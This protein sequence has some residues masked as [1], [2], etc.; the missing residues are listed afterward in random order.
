MFRM[1]ISAATCGR[2]SR[3]AKCP[4]IDKARFALIDSGANVSL[5]TPELLRVLQVAYEAYD[6]PQSISTVAGSRGD[7]LADGRVNVGGYLGVME[8]VVDA[9]HNLI[10]TEVL[11][12]RGVNVS[13]IAVD[14]T[15]VITHPDGL[16]VVISQY[17]PTRMWYLDVV[18][19][20]ELHCLAEVSMR[21]VNRAVREGV[22][23]DT[24]AYDKCQSIN[25]LIEK[26]LRLHRGMGHAT[27]MNLATGIRNGS[28][29]GT[30]LTYDDIRKVMT[31]LQCPACI[32]AKTA[33]KPEP[34]GSGIRSL[35]PF[36]SIAIDYLGK[37]D[38]AIGGWTGMI[39]GYDCHT[40]FGM[41]Y[42]V[43]SKD[44]D[45]YIEA[46][47]HFIRF[48]NRFRYEVRVVR[49]DAGSTEMSDTLGAYLS[50]RG[51]QVSP[52]APEFQRQNPAE[53]KIRTMKEMVAA[54][55][56]DQL[57]LPSQYWA[58]CAL[59]AIAC[60][61]T[62]SN[63]MC[64]DTSPNYQ[65]MG[66][67]TDTSKV[68]VHYFGELVVTKIVG[69]KVAM[70]MPRNELGVIVGKGNYYTKE[71]LIHR[72]G[73]SPYRPVCREDVRSV[74]LWELPVVNHQFQMMWAPRVTDRGITE[75]RCTR[76][77][78]SM[79]E[80]IRYPLKG[81]TDPPT[82]E[83]KVQGEVLITDFRSSICEMVAPL[84][85]ISADR[86]E[87]MLTPLPAVRENTGARGLRDVP[88]EEEPADTSPTRQDYF[89][90]DV[91]DRN[92]DEE[93]GEP[94]E[95]EGSGLTV[96]EVY[97][98]S[99][100]PSRAREPTGSGGGASRD[101]EPLS[102]TREPTGSGGGALRE[103]EPLSYTREPAG[104]G[105]AGEQGGRSE[106]DPLPRM[107]L[108]ETRRPDGGVNPW[109]SG[110][111]MTEDEKTRLRALQERRTLL[112]AAT[113]VE[114]IPDETD[115]IRADPGGV[116]CEPRDGHW[117]GD[118]H[119]SDGHWPGDALQ[120]HDC[121]SCTDCESLSSNRELLDIGKYRTSRL[122]VVEDTCS[123]IHCMLM[124]RVGES[125]AC[126]PVGEG[127]Q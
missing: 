29:V 11:M 10:S 12:S 23:S 21:Q 38:M 73:T 103:R 22:I 101:R 67:V 35:L 25:T 105:Q 114:H 7:L 20:M 112:A 61:N 119:Q 66:L 28:I 24:R 84:A 26:V 39:V 89:H 83:Q 59:H 46:M 87:K 126:R 97:R 15:C 18:Q 70:G 68:A 113:W 5:A 93:R 122:S 52:A 81:D 3:T 43:K 48:A 58:Q 16:R 115:S 33:A 17:A 123:N 106:T 95:P 125:S 56:E 55:M 14:K 2:L 4:E 82:A 62:V 49:T 63:V 6:T 108:R 78:L 69:Q 47:N 98:P 100:D 31:H 109:A 71:W 104:S 99:I 79:S 19:F 74:D 72:F 107:S 27:F 96:P 32:L 1:S 9:S 127:L 86:V 53:R 102:S 92:A 117:P 124:N 65:V 64:P 85:P 40:L 8:V 80:R 51:I 41:G 34:L 45:V 110:M 44:S 120:S 60:R 37:Y 116:G 30:D 13:F 75:V 76:E 88:E 36:D 91:W 118:A 94:R 77:S 121:D 57:M 42:L 54:M 50:N 111:G 90:S